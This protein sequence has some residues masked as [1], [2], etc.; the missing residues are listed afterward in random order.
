[1]LI[2]FREECICLWRKK[3]YISVVPEILVSFGCEAM[4]VYT[5]TEKLTR[6]CTGREVIILEGSE[7]FS[8][9]F[10]VGDCCRVSRNR[11]LCKIMFLDLLDD[12]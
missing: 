1:M 6:T 8:L 3:N 5:F 10:G 4:K 12:L 2:I 9:F 7:S 11:C